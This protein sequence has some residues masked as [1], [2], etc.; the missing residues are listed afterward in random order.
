[1][2]TIKAVIIWLFIIPLLV[3]A[4]QADSL[5]LRVRGVLID[6]ATHN[7]L[8]NGRLFAK[9]ANGRVTVST[10]GDSGQFSGMLPCGTTA[11]VVERTGYR[12]QIIPVRLSASVNAQT[13]MVVIPLLPVDKQNHDTPYLQTEQTSYVQQ[14]S[15]AIQSNQD[16]NHVQHSTFLVA[17]AILNKP[18]P[19]TVC[20]FYTKTGEKRCLSTNS[21]GWFNFDFNQKDIV[22]VEVSSIG[23]QPY[24]GNLIVEQL[25]GRSLQHQIRMQRELTLLSVRAPEATQCEL[26]T[27][28]KTIP[29]LSI[30]EAQGQYALYDLVP[31]AYELIVSYHER[32]VRQS[33]Q[34]EAG[35]NFFTVTQPR[36]GTINTL[37][38]SEATVPKVMAAEMTARPTLSLP[39]TIPMIYFEQGSYQ[40]RIDSQNVLRQVASYMKSHPAYVLQ[41]TGH[42]DNVGNPQINQSLSKYRALVTATFLTRQ[43]VSDRQLTKDGVGSSQP[44]APNDIETNRAL[45][46]RVSL[47]LTTAQ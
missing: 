11:L 16:S 13:V 27:K 28:T 20:F 33:V 19:A 18:L 37:A 36:T 10:N 12:S 25:D 1:M 40:L 38:N 15:A 14:D 26:R 44:M 5:C 46:R 41:I 45:N 39:D 2:S 32:V 7:P 3:Q 21:K 23:Y 6:Y 35:L 31:G 8:D 17:D 29:L 43:G 30:P 24:A 42:T 47:K 4:Q 22:A 9:T 34:L